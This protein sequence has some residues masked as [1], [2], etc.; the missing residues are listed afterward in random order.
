[1][2]SH[3]EY[4]K[5]VQTLNRHAQYYY[6]QNAPIISDTEYD[7]LY[8]QVVTFETHNPLLIDPNS[9]TQHIGSAPLNA[10]DSF[11]HHS[12]LP[13]L[14]NVFNSAE[15]DAFCQRVYT[16]L[17]TSAVEFCIE[18]K[19]DGIAV[20][21]H[22]DK[23]QLVAAAT[24][25]DGKTGE[26][27]TENVKTI[28][29][30]PLVLAKSITLEVRGEVYMRKSQFAQL[31]DK[32]ANPRNAA[33]GSMRQLDS[34]VTAS[35]QLDIMIYQ[36]IMDGIKT[37][38]EMMT[39]LDQLGFPVNPGLVVT[40]KVATLAQTAQSIDQERW[41]YPYEIDGGVIKV[42]RL[43]Y[44]DQLGMTV[45]APRWAVAYK[46]AAA[47]GVT[48]LNG[49]D[50]QVG[51]TGVLTPVAQLQPLSL[52]GV[53]ISNATLHNM[54]EIKRL[55][56]QIGDDVVVV[57]SGDVIPK[58]IRRAVAKPNAIPFEIPQ[59]CPECASSIVQEADAVAYRCQNPHC[60][61][62]FKAQ[63]SHFVSRKAMNIDGLGKEVIAKLVDDKQVTCLPDLYSLSMEELL[64]L[65]GFAEKSATA[66][67]SAIQASKTQPLHRLLFGLGI[68]FVGEQSAQLLAQR[69]SSLSALQLATYDELIEI[70][71]IGPKI[72]TAV[73]AAIQDEN[74]I[75]IITQLDEF[76][77]NPKNVI[78]NHDGPLS[79]QSFLITGTLS[80]YKR[81]EAEA[82]IK[83]NGGTVVQSVT[84]KLT[85]LI[86]GENPGSKLVKAEKINAKTVT[87]TIL[88]EQEF[89]QLLPS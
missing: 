32:F 41:D 67:L 31:T 46:F 4:V 70:E 22:Y 84:K 6:H 52:A 9:P 1:M 16:T 36:G 72:A 57:R 45:K 85:Y 88:N 2:L 64:R 60:P 62:R 82:L 5:L 15:L 48:Q 54:D 21:I 23:G 30:L 39:Q 49:I 81:S 26:L 12:I 89:S 40:T 8:Q 25:G 79:G 7:Q 76:G 10:F 14:G 74:F 20:A 13:S 24:R 56:I 29:S 69:Y 58:I 83:D 19:V 51:R 78:V 73:I 66:L 77:I 18:P 43:D 86:V 71:G 75:A 35:R 34:K 59:H 3:Q 11:T 65:P 61:A 27:V 47:E 28:R 53:T 37:H 68:A 42:N 44:Q 17:N 50:I 55:G 87:I 33:A 38:S 80:A 63:L